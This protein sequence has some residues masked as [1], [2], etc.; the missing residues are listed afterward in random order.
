MFTETQSKKVKKKKNI[1]ITRQ[2]GGM[3]SAYF[4]L[5][6]TFVP[7]SRGGGGGGGGGVLASRLG[8]NA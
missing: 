1:G 4:I 8:T 2:A 7:R 5:G 3:Q 6:N